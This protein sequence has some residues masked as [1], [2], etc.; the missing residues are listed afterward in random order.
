MAMNNQ[1]YTARQ[2]TEADIP[3]LKNVTGNDESRRLKPEGRSYHSENCFMVLE[4]DN[5]IIGSSYVLFARPL[6]WPDA[7]D[8]SQLPQFISL[9]VIDG[10]RNQ[11]AGTCLIGAIENEVKSRGLDRLYLGVD[12]EANPG[13]H[14]L[15]LRLEFESISEE[16]Y[17]ST[18]TYKDSEGVEH[19]E[20][21]WLID[22]VKYLA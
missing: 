12:V 4:A 17:R 13:A 19:E 10:Y 15:Y 1:R 14:R 5:K 6:A 16:P 20:V 11:G 18:W 22:M 21:D 3:A 2:A 8:T 7:E 9:V